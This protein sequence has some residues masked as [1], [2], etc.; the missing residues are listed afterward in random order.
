M[1]IYSIKAN[2]VPPRG[3]V[4]EPVPRKAATACGEAIVCARP[5]CTGFFLFST[6]RPSSTNVPVAGESVPSFK[7]IL[8][9]CF[10]DSDDAVGGGRGQAR[11]RG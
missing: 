5:S 8:Q 11:R 10:P 9:V 3:F 7:L 2:R 1:D 4:R 6:K